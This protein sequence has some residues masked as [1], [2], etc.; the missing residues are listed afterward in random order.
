VKTSRQGAS[1]VGLLVV[2]LGVG[3]LLGS[4]VGPGSGAAA[5]VRV[6]SGAGGPSGL[7]FGARMPD[8]GGA[9]RA[10]VGFVAVWARPR[11]GWHTAV[12]ALA[13]PQLAT[14]LDVTDPGKLPDAD[15]TGVPVV[16]SLAEDSAMVVVPLSTGQT[17]VVTVI[18]SGGGWLVHDIEPD[19]G[20]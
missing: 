16:R 14:A 9:V 2:G 20:N 19:V 18:P 5:P 10:A 7:P 3:L 1:G 8:A 11:D 4:N 12:E 15:P 13:T 17:V 6:T